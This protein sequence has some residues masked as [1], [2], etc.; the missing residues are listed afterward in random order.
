MNLD[1]AQIWNGY[2]EYLMTGNGIFSDEIVK[3]KFLLVCLDRYLFSMVTGNRYLP[4]G[5]KENVLSNTIIANVTFVQIGR[6][7]SN[8]TIFGFCYDSMNSL[9]SMTFSKS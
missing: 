7:S 6:A 2:Q 1:K 8:C 3:I 5:S 4:I 9:N